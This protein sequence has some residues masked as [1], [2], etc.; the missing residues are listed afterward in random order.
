M[1]R[2]YQLPNIR[3]G[4]P[5]PSPFCMK[6]ETYLRMTGIEYEVVVTVDLTKAPKGK[7]PFIEH[8]EH[9]IGDSQFILD[10]LRATFGDA[11][12]A[13]LNPKA[14][15]LGHLVRRTFEESLYFPMVYQ[16]WQ[17]DRG[18]EVTRD[19]YFRDAPAYA[20]PARAG[21]LSILRSQGTG[22]HSPAEVSALSAA[23]I[24]TLAEILGQQSFFLGAEPGSIDAGAYGFLANIAD[25][26]VPTAAADQVRSC[27]NLVAFCARMKERYYPDQ[28]R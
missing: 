11:L 22:R 28:R 5:N 23:D 20:E 14:K 19:L 16:R 25:V 26:P 2:L 17:E 18:W 1:L 15:V 7:L 10:Y 21:M 24:S 27:A 3:W 13:G 12:D 6:V 4:V 9:L 8:A